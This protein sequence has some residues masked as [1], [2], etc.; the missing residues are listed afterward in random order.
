MSYLPLRLSEPRTPISAFACASRRRSCFAL[1]RTELDFALPDT[2]DV[3]G[4]FF[5]VDGAHSG[6]LPL[7]CFVFPFFCFPFFG[8]LR[9]RGGPSVPPAPP[10]VFRL[11]VDSPDESRSPE[12]IML[13]S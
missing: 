2:E 1:L 12:R 7:T 5:D 9:A 11:G 3:A 10:P 4:V 8:F 13:Y 6:E